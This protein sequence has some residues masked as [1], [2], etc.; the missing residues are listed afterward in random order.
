VVL[1]VYHRH[2]GLAITSTAQPDANPRSAGCNDTT[3]GELPVNSTM[4]SKIEKARRYAE[5]PERVKF[6]RF[7][8]RFQGTHDEYT[9]KMDGS[10]FS[11]TCHF[12]EVQ[13]MG[14]CCHIMA[15]QRMLEAMMTEEQHT[16]GAPFSFATA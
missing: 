6:E 5:E 1:F 8:V 16:A 4:I 9:V 12:F 10:A 14:T 2:E 11:C 13:Q 7:E 15:L 3:R